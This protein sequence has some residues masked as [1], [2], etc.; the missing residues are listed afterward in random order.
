MQADFIVHIYSI[1]LFVLLKIC[2][3]SMKIIHF[4]GNKAFFSKKWWTFI[5]S[6]CIIVARNW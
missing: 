3:R 2:I 6:S 1:F 5:K 4:D